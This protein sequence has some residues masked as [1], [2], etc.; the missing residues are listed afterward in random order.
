[1]RISQTGQLNKSPS[2]ASKQNRWLD[3]DRRPYRDGE[4]PA[5]LRGHD[6]HGLRAEHRPSLRVWESKEP[7][8][9]SMPGEPR[10]E[11]VIV[12]PALQDSTRT[13]REIPI[14]HRGE[15][16]S[17]A[18]TDKTFS[19]I[20]LSV[21]LGIQLR[22]K[23]P[24]YHVLKSV[25][26]YCFSQMKPPTHRE[27]RSLKISGLGRENLRVLFSHLFLNAVSSPLCGP[28]VPAL[29]AEPPSHPL[30][31]PLLSPGQAASS[32]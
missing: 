10:N 26:R 17:K 1:M 27:L 7:V 3:G 6:A 15:R 9:S 32:G 13:P 30:P 21:G 22:M 8:P 29:S 16:D 25:G 31:G 18:K 5:S 12:H 24:S 28:R 14:T 4:L 19:V 2:T 11:C 20:T 23:T